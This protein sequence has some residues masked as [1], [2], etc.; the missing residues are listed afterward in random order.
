METLRCVPL[1]WR[2]AVMRQRGRA[3]GAAIFT[4]EVSTGAAGDLQRATEIALQMVTRF[5]MD[6]TVGPRASSVRR[7][8]SWDSVRGRRR[9]RDDRARDRHGARDIV[10][11]FCASGAPSSTKATFCC[12]PRRNLDR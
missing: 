5:G 1:Q 12:L 6:E 4:G 11:R 7:N 2:W 3:S 8:R 10:T 9:V